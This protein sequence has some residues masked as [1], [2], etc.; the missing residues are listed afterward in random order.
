VTGGAR[1]DGAGGDRAAP[2]IASARAYLRTGLPAIYQEGDFGMRF[3][4][5]LETLLDPVIGTLDSLPAVFD[6]RVT[7]RPVLMLL[8]AWLGIELDESWP[9]DRQRELV[10]RASELS[11]RRGTRA[12]L[13][14]ALRIA[15]PDLPLR[16]EDD[17]GV[18]HATDPAELPP[19]APPRFVVYCDIPL[20]EPAG[21]AR[22]IEV[23]KPVH[24]QYRLRIR[25]PR[26]GGEGA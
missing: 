23:M 1:A 26:R 13:E 20:E 3:V 6:C 9:E 16:V 21:L 15:F 18:V 12:G 19:A 8:A 5:A 7:G 24:V 4:G 14:E 10:R 22:M 2:P 25:A 11:R 17:G